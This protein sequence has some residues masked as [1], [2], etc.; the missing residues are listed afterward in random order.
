MISR[1]VP[2]HNI[3]RL[4]MDEKQLMQDKRWQRFYF[5]HTSSSLFGGYVTQT[6]IWWPQFDGRFGCV[7]LV[8]AN[9]ASSRNEGQS[10]EAY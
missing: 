3:V 9:V 7:M 4:T 1:S 8:A 5:M 2:S 6:A 10:T